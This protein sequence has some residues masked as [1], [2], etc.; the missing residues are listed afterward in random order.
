[1]L[2]YITTA[3]TKESVDEDERQ[4]GLDKCNH[5]SGWLFAILLAYIGIMEKNMETTIQGLGCRV[6]VI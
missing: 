3:R 4:G 5:F 6:G 2:Y 1:M